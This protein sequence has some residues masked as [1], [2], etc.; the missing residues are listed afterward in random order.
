MSLVTSQD[1]EIVD[2]LIDCGC[3]IQFEDHDSKFGYSKEKQ[4]LPLNSKMD[5]KEKHPLPLN[6]RMSWKP[7]TQH[8]APPTQIIA[9]T[10]A[11]SGEIATLLR[12][13]KVQ[14][15]AVRCHDENFKRHDETFKLLVEMELKFGIR[16]ND[17]EPRLEKVE[18]EVLELSSQAI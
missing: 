15:E 8:I 14:E 1:P 16:L 18:K 6:S 5:S 10:P 12:L 3:C 13:A 2:K 11:S 17:V 4:P 9:A 7:S